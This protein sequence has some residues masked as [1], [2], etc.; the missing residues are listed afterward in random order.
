MQVKAPARRGCTATQLP[1]AQ[2]PGGRASRAV[3][4]DAVVG[5]SARALHALAP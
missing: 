3:I 4:H 1:V 5:T 2:Y